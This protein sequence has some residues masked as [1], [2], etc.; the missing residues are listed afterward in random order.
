[1]FKEFIYTINNKYKTLLEKIDALFTQEEVEKIIS[2]TNMVIKEQKTTISRESVM[3]TYTGFYHTFIID[4]DFKD[5]KFIVFYPNDE[6]TSSVLQDVSDVNNSNGQIRFQLKENLS[7][8]D[9]N[10]KLNL[11]YVIYKGTG[12]KLHCTVVLKGADSRWN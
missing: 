10:Q 5:D 11:R 3:G 9:T 4:E 2:A 6:Y 7:K 12:Q 1:M 8:I